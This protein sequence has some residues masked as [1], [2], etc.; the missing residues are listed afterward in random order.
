[1][2]EGWA[3]TAIEVRER[4]EGDLAE[5]VRL[6]GGVQESAGYPVNW[7]E[8]PGHWLTPPDALGCWVVTVDGQVAGHVA[9]TADG[10][11]DALVERLYVDPERTG[12]GLG[13]RLLGHCVAVARE[14][15]RRLG[16]G[17]A[18]NCGAA[19]ALYRR[20]G[21]REA[22]RTPIDWGGDQASELIRF[23]A[24]TESAAPATGS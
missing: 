18:D 23:E 9:L 10:P 11:S 20:A 12:A 16:L 17:V 15:G 2:C 3:V 8:D 24:P 5:C 13:R 4:V 7:P 6:L 14:S 19:I 1:M 21:W 22:G